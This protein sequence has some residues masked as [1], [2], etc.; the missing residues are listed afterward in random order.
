MRSAGSREPY[1]RAAVLCGFAE[2]VSASGGD[3]AGL[4]ERAGIRPAALSDPE[5]LI[6]WRALGVVMELAATELEKP[7]F[8]LEWALAVP[9]PFLNVGPLGLLAG[10]SATLGGWLALSMRYWRFHTD[11]YSLQAL[12]AEPGGDLVLRFHHDALVF[13]SRHQMEYT[14]GSACE[15]ARTVAG[16][17]DDGCRLVRFRHLQPAETAFHERVFR[18]PVEFGSAHDEIV[19]DR[20][21]AARPMAGRLGPPA[22][23]FEPYLA[24][25]ARRMPL[26]DGS[27]RAA[28]ETAVA[29]LVGTGRCTLAHVARLMAVSPKKLQRLLA[30]ERTCFADILDRER[31]RMA[32]RLLAETAAPMASIAGL[33]GYSQTPPFTLAFKRW[34]GMAPR[35]YRKSMQQAARPGSVSVRPYA[36]RTVR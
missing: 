6:S 13:P 1:I 26:P 34:T 2:L 7:S 16:L 32:R 27:T 9:A 24:D 15:I 33:L 19:Y 28:V 11:A 18:C 35:D 29:S 12:E 25:R 14:L 20:G 21:L 31:Q 3:P 30:G 22:Q 4:A 17:A 36:A 23:T 10:F 5:M 8:G